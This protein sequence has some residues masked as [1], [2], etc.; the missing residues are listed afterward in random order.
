[1]YKPTEHV[2]QSG[3]YRCTTCGVVIPVN[4]GETLPTCPS[5]CGD[6]IWTFFNEKWHAP[7]GETRE[8]IDNFPALD[9]HGDA[10]QIPA[11]ARLTE[12]HLGP[13]PPGHP[14]G[15]PTLASFYYGGR[16]YFISAVELNQKTKPVPGN[17]P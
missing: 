9:L 5:R 1:M 2:I 10:E 8:A 7:A 6:A 16:V 17:G 15:D 14:L 11:G 4:A 13:A 12:V 3:L